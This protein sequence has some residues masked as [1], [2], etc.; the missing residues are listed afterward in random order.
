[1][2]V[3]HYMA[4]AV[5]VFAIS[6]ASILILLSGA[7]PIAVAFWRTAIAAIVLLPLL[8]IERRNNTYVPARND[9]ILMIISGTALATH[10]MTWIESLYLTTV[11]A[12][13][14]LVSTYPIF[15]LVM[16]RLIRERVGRQAIVGTLMAFLGVVLITVPEFYVSLRA[17]IGDLL[18]LAGAVSGA[19]YFMIG[20]AVR[21][22]AS[23]A[24]YTVP[25]Y[26]TSALVTLTTGLILRTRFW[27]YPP[28]TWFYIVMIVLGPM[29]LGHTLLNYSLRYSRAITVTTSTLG[30]PIGASL[31][32][33]IIFH[34]IPQPLTIV[35]IVITL[36]GIYLV[37]GE[38]IRTEQG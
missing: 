32:A 31:L 37:V 25:V 27:P 21:V 10:F 14:T 26:A 12:S 2:V 33:F 19:V 28:Y 35:G 20:R 16:G 15:T 3:R 8:M 6:W 24:M 38:E 7:Q 29:L 17:L 4:L 9:V 1:M 30:E 11:A 5:A 36:L 34:Q 23:L 22:K 18:A 13:T